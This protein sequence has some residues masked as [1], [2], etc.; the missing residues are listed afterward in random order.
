[1]KFSFIIFTLKINNMRIS[2]LLLLL[3]PVC[4][5]TSSGH[6]QTNKMAPVDFN[7]ELVKVT[8]N[9]YEL[10]RAWGTQFSA[11]N[12]GDKDFSQLAPARRKLTDYISAELKAVKE[13]KNIGVGADKLKKAMLDFLVFEEEMIFQGFIP[14][15]KLR[16]DT[17]KDE[18]TKATQ[19]LTELAGRENEVLEN[20][21]KAQEEYAAA[22]GFTIAAPAE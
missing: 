2:L 9:L 19:K 18:I 15:E 12:S 16:K 21:N 17:P 4:L 6:A 8:E 11:I 22:N 14:M 5:W 7:D 13:M 20:V 10:G 3:L 1:M